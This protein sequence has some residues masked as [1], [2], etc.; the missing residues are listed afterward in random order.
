M[1]RETMVWSIYGSKVYHSVPDCS[2]LK[3]AE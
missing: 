3:G 1:S 2:A